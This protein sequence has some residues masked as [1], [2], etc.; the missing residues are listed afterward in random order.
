MA[1]S[2]CRY[3]GCE[4]IG[5]QPNRMASL[6]TP[7]I[8]TINVPARSH[9]AA[10]AKVGRVETQTGN[11]REHMTVARVD[12]EPA[13]A[14]AFAVTKKIARRQ[15]LIEHAGVMERERNCAG[16]IVTVIVERS[17][18]PTP[19]VRTI[20]NCVDRPDCMF[21][22]VGGVRRRVSDSVSQH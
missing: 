17:V 16:A 19:N 3:V 10:V 21:D 5:L 15:R 6:K 8:A 14:A 9:I 20:A 7:G 1:V 22:R 12:R 18:S 4:W 11:H 2:S 13:A